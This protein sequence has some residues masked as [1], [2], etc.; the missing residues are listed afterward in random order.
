MLTTAKG[1]RHSGW[2]DSKINP[3][4]ISPLAGGGGGG[5]ARGGREIKARKEGV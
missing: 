1:P 2:W 3:T 5:R 4:L